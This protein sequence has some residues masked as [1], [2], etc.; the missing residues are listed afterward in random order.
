M[1]DY[2]YSFV[3]NEIQNNSY[4]LVMT[5]WYVNEQG[6]RIEVKDSI[7]TN[8][9]LTECFDLCQAFVIPE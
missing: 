4:A 9:T 3:I 2:K 6:Q 8:K 7:Q 1:I 5:C